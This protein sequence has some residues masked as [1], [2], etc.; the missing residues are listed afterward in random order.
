[1]DLK[2][3]WDPSLK[4]FHSTKIGELTCK[5]PW[6]RKSQ[7]HKQHKLHCRFTHSHLILFL[8]AD[9]CGREKGDRR[10]CKFLKQGEGPSNRNRLAGR[11]SGWYWRTQTECRAGSLVAAETCLPEPHLPTPIPST[12]SPDFSK[13]LW[14]LE[15]ILGWEFQ[16][17]IL[18]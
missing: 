10:P 14:H 11:A 3:E 4:V 16:K 7:Q 13:W 17:R 5:Y 15:G 2:T 1:M 12:L 6:E 8:S 9:F 18:N